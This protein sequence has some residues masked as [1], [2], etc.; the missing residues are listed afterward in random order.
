MVNPSSEIENICFY[1]LKHSEFNIDQICTHSFSIQKLRV[2][3]FV[4]FWRR[5]NVCSAENEL[6]NMCGR[7]HQNELEKHPI[8][9]THLYAYIYKYIDIYI[10]ICLGRRHWSTRFSERCP[11]NDSKGYFFVNTCRTVYFEIIFLLLL[12]CF[13][14]LTGFLCKRWVKKDEESGRE[15]EIVDSGGGRG[16]RKVG[17][18]GREIGQVTVYYSSRLYSRWRVSLL[19]VC[20]SALQC[21][22]VCCSVLQWIVW[23]AAQ[24]KAGGWGAHMVRHSVSVCLYYSVLQFTVCYIVFVCCSMLQCAWGGEWRGGRKTCWPVAHG[25]DC[26]R[27][28]SE[29]HTNSHIHTQTP[30]LTIVHANTP[31]LP[32][33]HPPTPIHSHS[34]FLRLAHP[35][36]LTLRFAREDGDLDLSIYIRKHQNTKRTFPLANSRTHETSIRFIGILLQIPA[37]AHIHTHTHTNTH[38]HT[39]SLSLSLSLSV[40]LS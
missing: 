39:Y 15:R 12:R 28:I 21:V 6:W 23:C 33:S 3:R 17:A 8:L 5:S 19:L 4:A 20:W 32:P 30:T 40:S 26:K 1:R 31:T 13:F 36:E 9:N 14:L 27:S 29:V 11:D 10:Y 38:P 34:P 22:A 35:R 16:G 7:C 24:G 37:P 18:G 2:T 25:R